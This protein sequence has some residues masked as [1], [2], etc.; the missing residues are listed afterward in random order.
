MLP[1][2]RFGVVCWP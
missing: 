1:N 2:Q